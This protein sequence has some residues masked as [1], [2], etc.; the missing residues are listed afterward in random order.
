[1]V[2]IT[3]PI[4]PSE[5]KTAHSAGRVQLQV[6]R[7]GVAVTN[8]APFEYRQLPA[9]GPMV[10]PLHSEGPLTLQW[11]NSLLSMLVSR[12]E[13]LSTQLISQG[14]GIDQHVV[15][16]VRDP[17]YF[18]TLVISLLILYILLTTENVPRKRRSGAAE[19]RRPIGIHL[20]TVGDKTMESCSSI[21]HHG[22]FR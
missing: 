13:S 2:H 12:L 1:M 21:G 10:H 17:E 3:D 22:R 14:S 11:T 5:I 18:S 9:A 19:R 4:F 15:S 16:L 20:S 8:S 7:H 6:A